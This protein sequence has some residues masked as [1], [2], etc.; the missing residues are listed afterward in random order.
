MALASRMRVLVLMLMLVMVLLVLVL[1]VVSNLPPFLR[2]RHA[3]FRYTLTL[4]DEGLGLAMRVGCLSMR[5]AS[6]DRRETR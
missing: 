6:L 5:R 2:C 1:L 4:W 3:A